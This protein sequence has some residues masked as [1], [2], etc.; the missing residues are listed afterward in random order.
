MIF[1]SYTLDRKSSAKR[2]IQSLSYEY[3]QR[4]REMQARRLC[5]V[6]HLEAHLLPSCPQVQMRTHVIVLL[7]KGQQAVL[8]VEWKV[9]F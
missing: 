4:E 2:L 9:I 8:P 1:Q 6:L 5:W 7:G 3:L